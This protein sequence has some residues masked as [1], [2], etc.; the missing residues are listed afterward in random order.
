MKKVLMVL[1]LLVV[2]F[3]SVT[4]VSAGNGYVTLWYPGPES[5]DL[6]TR[7]FCVTTPPM[8]DEYCWF[9]ADDA[10]IT[11]PKQRGP[12]SLEDI[13]TLTSSERDLYSVLQLVDGVITRISIVR[14]GYD[15]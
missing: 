10:H 7:Q 5:I 6:A 13:A 14:Y 2:M 9:V 11:V 15:H 12:A 3:A 8:D 4:P 1:C